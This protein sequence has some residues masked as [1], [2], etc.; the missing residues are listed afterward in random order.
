MNDSTNNPSDLFE[1]GV[2]PEPVTEDIPAPKPGRFSVFGSLQSF[3]LYAFLLASLF[4]LFTPD[5]LSPGKRR[6]VFF[7]PGRR[8]R[9]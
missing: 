4:T 2:S 1:N 5:N 8:T 6:I 9:P 7:K 3:F